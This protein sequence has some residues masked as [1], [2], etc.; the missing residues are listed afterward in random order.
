MET[1][2][3]L[4]I[5]RYIC[6]LSNYPPILYDFYQQVTTP[7]VYRYYINR[8]TYEK[9]LNSEEDYN[10]KLNKL[11]EEALSAIPRST[12][13][14]DSGDFSLTI[15]ITEDFIREYTESDANE[16]FFSYFIKRLCMIN[17]DYVE[18]RIFD[19]I[20][21]FRDIMPRNRPIFWENLEILVQEHT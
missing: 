18:G 19:I 5:D 14:I 3:E 13:T 2:S 20:T 21:F 1:F 6:N 12:F 11:T 9:I 16:H 15:F 17:E 7:D 10:G 8:Q 4:N